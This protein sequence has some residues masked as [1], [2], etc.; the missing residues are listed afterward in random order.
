M[1]QINIIGVGQGIH[2]LTQTHLNLINECDI[3]VGGTRLLEMVDSSGKQTFP[4]NSQI[5]ELMEQLKVKA[6]THKI[7]VLASGDPLFH[8]IG[9][10]I[11]RHFNADQINIHSNISSISA[12]FAAI[13]EPWHDAKIISLHGKTTNS[14]SFSTIGQET[15]VAFLTDPEKNP[16]YIAKN[17]IKAGALNFKL[18]VLENLG[19]NEKEN[20]SW[21]ETLEEVRDKR[22]DHP[23]IVII[24]KK[25][26]TD[27]RPVV[28]R[29]TYIGMDEEQFKYTAYKDQGGLITKSEVRAVSLSKLKLT[30]KDHVLWDIGAGSGSVSIEAGLLLPQ[31]QVY[32]IEKHPS[33]IKD[34]SDNISAFNCSNISVINAAFPDNIDELNQPDR[35]FIGGGGSQLQSIL[36][37]ACDHLLDSGVIVVNT[38]LIQTL[39]TTMRILQTNGFNPQAIQIQVARSKPMPYSHRF[40]PLSPVWIISGSKP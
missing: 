35:I 12:A 15:K 16:N 5:H 17:L 36:N 3:L 27:T 40:E 37:T 26:S 30:K 25:D 1:N 22:F 39:E 11:C 29:E 24:K 31:G 38:V 2:D 4:V 20:I 32:A 14:F 6:A 19:N 13:K 9:A 34:I 7:V 21:F 28:P 8:G 10:T 18:C 23:N 33:R